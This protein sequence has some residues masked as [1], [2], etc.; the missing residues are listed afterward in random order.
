MNFFSAALNF[1][2]LNASFASATRPKRTNISK[3]HRSS[4]VFTFSTKFPRTPNV[5]KKSNPKK[6]KK[7]IPK[8]TDQME[9]FKKD[10][11]KIADHG[12]KFALFEPSERQ[13]SGSVA[14]EDSP[15][16]P[17]LKE[18]LTNHFKF[19][20]LVQV[21]VFSLKKFKNSNDLVI[22]S[23]TGSGKTLAYLLPIFQELKKE[24]V[25][26]MEP[27]SENLPDFDKNFNEIAHDISG[28]M[29]D[30]TLI[31]LNSGL[32]GL[33]KARQPRAIILVPS[34]EL[35][36]QITKVAKF[37][38]H[39]CKL[40]VCGFHAKM[41][42]KE[43]KTNLEKPIDIM[44][45]TP[46]L[47]GKYVGNRQFGFSKTKFVVLDEA[48]TLF[49]EGFSKEL[50][51][52]IDSIKKASESIKNNVKWIFSSATLPRRIL[53]NIALKFPVTDKIIT[54]KLHKPLPVQQFFLRIDSS[55]TKHNLLLDTLKFEVVKEPRILIFC[56]TLKSC[57]LVTTFLKSKSYNAFNI[58]SSTLIKDRISVWDSFKEKGSIKDGCTI[59]VTTDLGSRGIDTLHCRSVI[60]FDFPQTTID[61]IHRAGRVGRMGRNG[62]VTSFVGKRDRRLADKI[63]LA[64][65]KRQLLTE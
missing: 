25:A 7:P 8:M 44:I 24:E 39:Y 60:L 15:L 21:Q 34:R 50:E 3:P 29:D 20:D 17:E 48:D 46:G 56:N 54:G 51:P 26:S 12:R 49:D 41:D 40:V 16:S 36:V 18:A 1:K 32:A 62:K 5:V 38:S 14:V 13:E 58:S 9:K 31:P 42:P 2:H 55:T 35:V 19:K 4:S 47:L 23:E 64:V 33:R 65:R 28:M 27:D 61:Y 10:Q 52:V 63:Q 59:V 53:K 37:L 43:L 22:A 30:G 6:L 57:E 45:T 11:E